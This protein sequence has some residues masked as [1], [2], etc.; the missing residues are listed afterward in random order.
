MA[1]EKELYHKS[2]PILIRPQKQTLFLRDQ[3]EEINKPNIMTVF[4]EAVDL[5]S[6]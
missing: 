3:M 2:I 5:A 4:G 6:K 1:L